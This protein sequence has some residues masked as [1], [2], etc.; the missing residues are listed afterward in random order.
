MRFL[1]SYLFWTYERGSFHY[2][3]MVTLILAFIFVS[4][5]FINFGDK[6]AERLPAPG[7]VMVVNGQGLSLIYQINVKALDTKDADRDLK[8]SMLRVIEPI[9]GGV[10]VDRYEPVKDTNGKLVAYRV[11]VRR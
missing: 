4:P 2:D 1:K 9:S 8:A 3:V 11:W 10:V 7:E 5:R 6:P